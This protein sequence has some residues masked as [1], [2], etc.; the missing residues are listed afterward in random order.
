MSSRYNKLYHGS[1]DQVLYELDA[2]S[3][4]EAEARAVFA[5][6]IRVIVAQARRIEKLERKGTIP[7]GCG[8]L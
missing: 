2:G 6:L 8:P 4:T 3:I 1:V 5:N 7:P